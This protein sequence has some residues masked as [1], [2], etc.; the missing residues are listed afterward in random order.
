[1]DRSELLENA[2]SRFSALSSV[3]DD[4]QAAL[5]ARDEAAMSAIARRKQSLLDEIAQLEP[6][7]TQVLEEA[8]TTS[9]ADSAVTGLRDLLAECRSKNQLNGQLVASGLNVM[10]KSI[11]M[12][13]SLMQIGRVRTYDAE[14]RRERGVAKRNIGIA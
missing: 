1:M 13:E 14:G 8:A 7:L 9:Q 2:V 3:L 10:E 12:L 5:A 4:E 6:Q 11:A